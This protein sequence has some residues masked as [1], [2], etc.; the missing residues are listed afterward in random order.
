[1]IIETPHLYKCNYITF[2]FAS[3]CWQQ[4]QYWALRKSI[5]CDEQQIFKDHDR[6]GV[7]KRAIPIVAECSYVGQVDQVIGVVRI[8]ERQPGIWW[9]SRLGVSMLYRQLSRFQTCGLF[10]DNV[11]V[12]PFTMNIGGALIYKALSTALAIGCK[13][14]YAYVQ[15]QNVNF[16][17]RMHWVSLEVKDYHG[18]THHLMKCDLAYY[19]ASSISIQQ[20]N[21]HYAA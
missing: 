3:E 7:D 8:N 11:P 2:D 15:E 13:E 6:D 17:K 5:F 10:D 14:F 19:K 12:H 21:G 4:D 1:M 18:K 9:G 20:L 16:F